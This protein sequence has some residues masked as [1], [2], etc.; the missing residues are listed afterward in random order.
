[1]KHKNKKSKVIKKKFINEE[2]REWTAE[3]LM[4]L[5]HS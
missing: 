4:E 3:E 1:M 5:G 2:V